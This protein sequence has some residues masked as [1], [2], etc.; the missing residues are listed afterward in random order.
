MPDKILADKI[1]LVTGGGRGIG[2]A[3]CRL[4]GARGY[5]VVVNYQRD[6]AAADAVVADIAAAGGRAVAIQADVSREAEV[7]RLFGEID[8]RFGRLTHLVNN[9][10]ISSRGQRLDAVDAATLEA[11]FDIN[12]L[13]SF[14]C[15]RAAVRRMSTQNGGTGGAIVNLSSAAATLGSPGEF[16][17]Y[18]ASKAAVD[19]LTFGLAKEVGREGI[20]VN[21]VAPG[22][23][24]TEIHAS[25]GEP[26]RVGRIA[27]TVP[28]GR[29][30]T[31]EEVAEAILFLLSDAASYATGTILRI[32]GGR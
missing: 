24:L 8:G 2:A 5:A 10:G 30:G 20:R 22:L 1:L 26:D 25:S 13:G 23:V 7:E 29:A 15:A 18:A 17:W 4:A 14:L 19:T 21:A 11:V 3:T 31:P 32:S 6:A 27:P 16:V 28:M 12:I 9:A